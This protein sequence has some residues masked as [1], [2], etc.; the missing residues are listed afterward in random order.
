MTTLRHLSTDIKDQISFLQVIDG[1]VEIAIYLSLLTDVEASS[2]LHSV[3][4]V[5]RC[6]YY[7]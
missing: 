4:R 7:M 6:Y 3:L 2:S 1:A 5:F